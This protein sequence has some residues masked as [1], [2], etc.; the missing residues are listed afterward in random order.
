VPPVRARGK[1]EENP[2]TSIMPMRR[3]RYTSRYDEKLMAIGFSGPA[4]YLDS[5]PALNL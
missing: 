5:P 4:H 2:K 1:P 3:L